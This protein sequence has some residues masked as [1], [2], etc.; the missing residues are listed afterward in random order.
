MI[1]KKSALESNMIVCMRCTY[2]INDRTFN[3]F[4]Q[5]LIVLS[6]LRM[7]DDTKMEVK[8]KSYTHTID[9]YQ[10]HKYRYTDIPIY[11]HIDR[12]LKQIANCCEF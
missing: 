5:I 11:I 12:W 4:P 9:S 10:R 6:S 7:N 2:N 1:E 3:F 8:K